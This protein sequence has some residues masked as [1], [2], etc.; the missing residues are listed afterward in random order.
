[1]CWRRTE[2]ISSKDRVGNILQTMKRMKGNWVGQFV[3]R[4]CLL[5]HVVEG[6]L[7]GGSDTKARKKT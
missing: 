7:E 1:M 4:N 3:C 2:D 6:R 5:R